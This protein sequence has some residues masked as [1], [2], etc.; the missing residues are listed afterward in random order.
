MSCVRRSL[1]VNVTRVPGATVSDFGDTP[2]DVIVKV[3]PPPGV[4]EGVGVGVG[5]G[6]GDGA[7][8]GDGLGDGLGDVPSPPPHP[9]TVI[10]HAAATATTVRIADGL[11]STNLPKIRIPLR[12]F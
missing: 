2:A 5:E 11:I 1:L 9:A 6:A 3:V 8:A 7:G 4:G 10:M 12:W